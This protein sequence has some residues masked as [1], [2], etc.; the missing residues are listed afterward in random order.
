[1]EGRPHRLLSV[2][3]VIVRLRQFQLPDVSLVG[4]E[5][6]GEPPY[7]QL[8]ALT[9]EESLDAFTGKT[10]HKKLKDA[11]AHTFADRQEWAALFI[12][13]TVAG[14]V[15]VAYLHKKHSQR[16]H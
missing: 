6:T 8:T 1:M 4:I 3:G 9:T 12:G 2:E 7:T 11:V 10:R 13:T 5:P 14:V 16:E 15:C